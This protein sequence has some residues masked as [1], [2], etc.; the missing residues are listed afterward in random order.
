MQTQVFIAHHDYPSRVRET[1]EQKLQSLLRFHP[2]TVSMRAL[3]ERHNE[4]HRVEIVASVGGG[5]VLVADAR[6]DAFT[7]ALDEALDRMERLLKRHNG[8]RHEARR[9]AP[10]A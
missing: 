10:R 5:A 3:L 7:S 4:E 6:K 9:R 2:R 8:K 1:V